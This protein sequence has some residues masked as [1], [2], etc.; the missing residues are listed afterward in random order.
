MNLDGL[1]LDGDRERLGQ[2]SIV[3]M[4]LSCNVLFCCIV[5]FDSCMSCNVM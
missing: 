1:N 4:L 5:L 2:E 3:W